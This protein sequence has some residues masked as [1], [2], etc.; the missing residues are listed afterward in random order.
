MKG[1]LKRQREYLS[2][3]AQNNAIRTYHM[4]DKTQENGK[5]RLCGDRDEIINHIISECCKLAQ[6]YKTRRDWVGKLIHLKMCKK[7]KIDPTNKCYMHNT[8]YAIAKDAHKLLWDFDIQTD[9]IISARRPD[10]MIINQKR[11]L[12]KLS[13]LLSRLTTE[14]N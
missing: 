11:E 12:A 13:T 4:K 14:S 6:G 1:N 7:F 9:P 5:Y 3:A 10:L 8:A 2:I